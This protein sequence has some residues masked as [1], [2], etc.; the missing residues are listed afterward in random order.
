MDEFL[1][2]ERAQDDRFEFD[3]NGPVAMT[4]GTVAHR[5]IADDLAR[6][7]NDRLGTR[8][9]ALA[10]DVKVIVAGRVRYPDVVVS[11]A[12]LI[13]GADVVT[14]P[15]LVVEISS[16]STARTDRVAKLEEYRRTPSIQH[17]LLL[18]QEAKEG[19]L[20]TRDGETWRA[21]VLNAFG[22]VALGALGVAIPMAE[23]YRRVTPTE[24][25]P[26]P[27]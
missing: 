8:C 5:R 23:I 24:P 22:E 13:G 27:P 10:G 25:T 20:Y 1:V 21:E 19:T 6:A 18:E 2:W 17:Y 7:L 9:E 3:G 4:G 16:A 15:V 12:D 14:D 11:C 26:A